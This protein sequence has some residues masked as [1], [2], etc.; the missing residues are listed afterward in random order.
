MLLVEKIQF[1]LYNINKAD[2]ILLIQKTWQQG[3][4]TWNI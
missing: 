4:N 1:I 2:F 3:I